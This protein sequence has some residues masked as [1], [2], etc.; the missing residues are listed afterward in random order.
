MATEVDQTA[1]YYAHY[2]HLQLQQETN[3]RRQQ[4]SRPASGAT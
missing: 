4:L 3:A 1:T 2:E